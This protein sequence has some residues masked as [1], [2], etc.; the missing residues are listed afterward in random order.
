MYSSYV[1]DVSIFIMAGASHRS[2]LESYL[3]FTKVLEDDNVTKRGDRSF[4]K[5]AQYKYGF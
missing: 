1:T 3:N 2:F 5:P 4:E